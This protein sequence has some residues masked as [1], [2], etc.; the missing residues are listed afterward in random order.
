MT[1]H[2]DPSTLT[3]QVTPDLLGILNADGVFTE[4][5][6]SWFNTMGRLP[7]EIEG[8]SFLHFIHPDDIAPARRAFRKMR[9][10]DPVLRVEYRFRHRDGAY[11]WLS[12]NA[13]PEGDLFF[14]NARDITAE[15]Q[16]AATLQT[17]DDEARL[18]EQFVAV[19]GHDL[20]N[21]IAAIDAA[22]SLLALEPQQDSSMEM[23]NWGREAV[24]RMTR[25]INDVTDFARARLGE[26]LAVSCVDDCLLEAV[27]AQ[28]I[29]EIR[30]ANPDVA[31]HADI[32]LPGKY[33]CDPDRIAQMLSNLIGNAVAHGSVDK[34]IK[35]IGKAMDAGVALAVENGGDPIPPTAMP[36]LFE[37]FSRTDGQGAQSGLGLGLF[38]ANQIAVGHG[39]DLKVRSDTNGT[40]FTFIMPVSPPACPSLNM[41]AEPEA[42]R[43]FF[44]CLNCGKEQAFR[45]G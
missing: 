43:P 34:P 13:V 33:P 30:L 8:R 7:S 17:R 18:R 22:L 45:T 1:M 27:V 40:A 12:W 26:G 4:V 5:N 2:I 36:Y 14:C 25:L 29:E 31:I 44:N 9:Q 37:P 16:S 28:V 20:R 21:P 6:H 10:G 24:G 39:G 19:L 11:L 23:I 41:G 32:D 35:V 42:T 3:W 15:K 38:I